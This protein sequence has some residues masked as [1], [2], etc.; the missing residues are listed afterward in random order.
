MPNR[1]PKQ[2]SPTTESL[3]SDRDAALED[4]PDIRAAEL[5][6]LKFFKKIRPLL[7]SLH[8]IGTGVLPKNWSMSYESVPANNGQGDSRDET[9]TKAT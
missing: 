4:S 2:R 6:G 9:S 7:D 5:Q 3:G 8:E 1:P